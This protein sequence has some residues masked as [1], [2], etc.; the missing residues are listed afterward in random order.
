[1]K[2]YTSYRRPRTGEYGKGRLIGATIV[3]AVILII[4]ML[5][6]GFVRNAARGGVASVYGWG[7]RFIEA[8]M[9]TGF[10]SSRRSLAEQN[11]TLTERLSTLEVGEQNYNALLAENE[12][13]KALL[14]VAGPGLGGAAGITAPVV[15]SIRSSP[16]GTFLIG[17]GLSDGV[18]NGSYVVAAGGTVVGVVRDT[19]KRVSVVSEIFGPGREEEGVINGA[20]VTLEGS[21]GGNAY[22]KVPRGLAVSIGD[23]VIAPQYGSRIVG[24]VGKTAS[25]SASASQDVYIRLP[26]NFSTQRYVY[27][28]PA[29]I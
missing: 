17:A 16:Y 26:I 14:R 19:G 25:S 15:S 21:G 27:I 1:M 8:A 2:G 5:S 24:I 9:D 10:F 28:I 29:D 4:D 6:G 3:V 11:R 20:S 13:L 7:D 18:R 12:A 23:P 22:A